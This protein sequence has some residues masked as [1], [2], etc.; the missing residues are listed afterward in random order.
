MWCLYLEST[1]MS[2]CTLG[3]LSRKQRAWGC[4]PK[5]TGPSFPFLFH[6]VF[7]C[8]HSSFPFPS[9]FPCPFIP[10]VSLFTFSLDFFFSLLVLLCFLVVVI[11]C[12]MHKDWF[13]LVFRGKKLPGLKFLLLWIA[14]SWGARKQPVTAPRGQQWTCNTSAYC[15]FYGKIGTAR[16]WPQVLCMWL[17]WARYHIYSS[18]LVPLSSVHFH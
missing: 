1:G 14:H 13:Y 4:Y 2:G 17:R 3:R 18:H 15:W 7:S 5:A 9:W 16:P 12:S 6:P 10:F 8:A 11:Y